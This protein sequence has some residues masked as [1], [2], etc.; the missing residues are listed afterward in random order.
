MRH[1]HCHASLGWIDHKHTHNLTRVATKRMPDHD[2]CHDASHYIKALEVD[3][4]ADKFTWNAAL[5]PSLRVMLLGMPPFKPPSRPF[6]VTWVLRTRGG[7]CFSTWTPLVFFSHIKNTSW[8]VVLA[9]W[10]KCSTCCKPNRP[11]VQV[12]QNNE[13]TKAKDHTLKYHSGNINTIS[14][15]SG[16]QSITNDV[17]PLH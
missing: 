17:W 8:A 13:W 7:S 11:V 6:Q 1:D 3:N 4:S 15:I 12:S 2:L 16:E 5:V 14:T 10:I 9:G